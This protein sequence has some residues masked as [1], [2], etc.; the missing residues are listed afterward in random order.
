[1]HLDKASVKSKPS[2]EGRKE[3]FFTNGL[4]E[5]FMNNPFLKG[6]LT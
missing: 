3:M 5:Q 4:Q 2:K 6:V 1:M